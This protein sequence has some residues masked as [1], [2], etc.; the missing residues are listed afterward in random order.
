M[1]MVLVK[2]KSALPKEFGK[3]LWSYNLSRVNPDRDKKVIIT[4]TINYG[5]LGEWRWIIRRYGKNQIRRIL[6]NSPISE[7]RPHIRKLV[8]IIFNID[9]FNHAPRGAY[10]K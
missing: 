5:N 1:T 10:R 8:S 7:I 3:I 6:R 9:E 2:R 4:N